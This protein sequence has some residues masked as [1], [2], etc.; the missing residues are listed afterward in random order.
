MINNNND[1]NPFERKPNSCR[2][3]PSNLGE[4]SDIPDKMSEELANISNL[5]PQTGS[6]STEEGFQ[7]MLGILGK[8]APQM[9]DK[10]VQDTPKKQ[11]SVFA[12]KDPVTETHFHTTPPP[13]ENKVQEPPK[14]PEKKEDVEDP[15]KTKTVS[16][17]LGLNY[18]DDEI[19]PILDSLM[20]KGYASET[21][22]FKDN[23][24]TF[25]VAYSWEEQEIMKRLD[26]KISEGD[27][28]LKQTGSYFYDLYCLA[29]ALERF[30][31]NY[32]EPISS[33][34]QET[35]QKSF[36]DRLDFLS[37]LASPF[38]TIL[39]QKR[40]DF[41]KKIQYLTDNINKYVK[42]F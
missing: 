15:N 38:I 13:V 11:E 36:D 16:E 4:S 12:K 28:N 29:A 3:M 10:P 32:F 27:L 26:K 8:V 9:E 39:I 23:P 25:R 24:I 22:H 20:T 35:L 37:S 34:D 42:A 18:S 14:E 33:G 17:A 5:I 7:K 2:E 6:A 1:T 41:I 40:L 31:A 19:L 21:L 30:G